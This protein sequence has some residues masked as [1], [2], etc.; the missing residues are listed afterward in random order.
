[1]PQIYSNTNYWVSIVEE[2]K[3]KFVEEREQC[4]RVWE[5][6]NQTMANLQFPTFGSSLY[7]QSINNVSMGL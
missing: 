2:S 7:F 5:K 4:N 6:V 3:E 1:M